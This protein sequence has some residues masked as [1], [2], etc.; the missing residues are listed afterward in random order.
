MTPVLEGTPRGPTR[1][2][3]EL[4]GF[5]SSTVIDQAARL[6]SNLVVAAALGP[7]A[8]GVWF[9]L[10]LVLQYGAMVHLGVLNG[11][12]REI[13]A[14]MARDD[15]EEA[16]RLR[17]VALGFVLLSFLVALGVLGGVLVPLG[18]VPVGSLAW[19]MAALLA[20]QQLYAFAFM[21]LK[22][23]T[24][25]LAAARLQ[26]ISGLTFPVATIPL[27]LTWG[28]EGYVAGQAIAYGLLAGIATIRAPELFRPRFDR[29]RSAHL[30]RIGFPIM[31]VGITYAV[32]ATVDRWVIQAHLGTA[33]LG[34][35]SLAIMALGA[36]GLLPQV[37]AQQVYPRMAMAWSR[38]PTWSSLEPL[39]KRQQ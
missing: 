16:N 29:S 7:T 22:A 34:H 14:A 8:M 35:Y 13:P 25:F 33:A 1:W 18:I 19:L 24:Q 23:R 27:A 17:A 9:L 15:P 36:V 6:G 10:N 28:L 4:A 20:T 32:F 26:L 39:M 12:N 21:H 5:G 31:L 2:L 11:M 38:N 3:R 37:V 30:V